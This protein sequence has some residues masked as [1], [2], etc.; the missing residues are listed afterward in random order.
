MTR[1]FINEHAAGQRQPKAEAKKVGATR[2]C[3]HLIVV[4]FTNFSSERAHLPTISTISTT[5]AIS[6]L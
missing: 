3:L 1:F 4:F 2:C 5:P 6:H